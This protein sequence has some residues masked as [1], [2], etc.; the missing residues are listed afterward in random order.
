MNKRSAGVLLPIASLPGPF[1]I[2]TLGIEAF[3]FIDRISDMGFSW[4]QILPIGPLDGGNSP[5]AGNS[6]FAGNP[7]LID[8]SALC[9]VGYLTREEAMSA[10]YSGTAHTVDYAFAAKNSERVLRLAYARI[11]EPNRAA[12][13]AFAAENPWAEDYALFMAIRERQNG[14]PWQEWGTYACYANAVRDRAVFADG[15]A[16]YLFVQYLFYQQWNAVKTYAAKKGVGILGDIPVYVALDSCDV[17]AHPEQFELDEQTLQP[18][19]VA[20]VPPD[21]FSED[22]QLWGNPLYNWDVMK[23]RGFDWWL[24]RLNHALKLYDTVR[25]DHFRGLASYWA[26]PADAR[27]AKEGCWEEAAGKDLF[28]ALFAQNPQP[29]VVAEDLGVFGE[30]VEELLRY[31]GFAGM[32]VLQFGF[33][34][35]DD[36]DNIHRPHCYPKNA[37]A[38]TGTHDNNTLLGWLWEATP[39]EKET[40]L[41]YCG[42]EGG[43]WGC[44]GP[45][46]P[47]C[48]ALIETLWRSAA[49][50][51]FVPVPD[52]CGFGKDTR[53]N[54]PGVPQ[55]NWRY[56]VVTQDLDRIDAAYFR[57]INALFGR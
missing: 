16:Y 11:T 25:I 49:D 6:A 30:D 52:M 47:V 28:A 50:M 51:A 24:G 36:A 46:S 55:D 17:W 41:R 3:R 20:G 43:D 8:P 38:Y 2:G 57:A 37:L 48:R 14:A 54:V 5:Y 42:Y 31:T 10:V 1:G 34:P 23:Q 40:A 15:I 45:H 4:W 22:G 44:G 29:S 33:D 19:R 12:I 21:Y 32:R 26:I 35:W 27:S 9:E 53:L 7:L 56:R 39:K 18:K 13:H